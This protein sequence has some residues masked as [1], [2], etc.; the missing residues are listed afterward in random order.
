MGHTAHMTLEFDGMS[1]ATC[2]NCGVHVVPSEVA[3][4]LAGGHWPESA[5]TEIGRAH[6]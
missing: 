2:K 5:P 1:P 3:H 6:V 4:D